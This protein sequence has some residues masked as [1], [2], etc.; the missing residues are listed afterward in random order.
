MTDQEEG[1]NTKLS[2]DIVQVPMENRLTSLPSRN[3]PE[4]VTDDFQNTGSESSYQHF[5]VKPEA[6]KVEEF[7][8]KTL[9]HVRQEVK[10]IG[11][12]EKGMLIAKQSNLLV[13]IH[14]N[15]HVSDHLFAP[16]L[17]ALYP[18]LRSDE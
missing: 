2:T 8:T 4:N 14:E 1:T 18:S 5:S 11:L 10:A 15:N 12:H 13:I 9:E 7:E 17:S 3:L 6:S 16:S